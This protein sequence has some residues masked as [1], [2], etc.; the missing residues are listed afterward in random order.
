MS[1][2]I[3]FIFNLKNAYFFIRPSRANK[4]CSDIPSAKIFINEKWQNNHRQLARSL[5]RKNGSDLKGQSYKNFGEIRVW[6][7]SLG[8]N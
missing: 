4:N 6:G 1:K 3:I 5:F 7:I 8:L 2:F